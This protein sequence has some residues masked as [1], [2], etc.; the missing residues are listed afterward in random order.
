MTGLRY[1]IFKLY[2]QA[3]DIKSPSTIKSQ[4]I[5]WSYYPVFE[6]E[7]NAKNGVIWHDE[8]GNYERY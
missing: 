6:Q 3:K 5:G 7:D 2:G 1:T 8:R 4:K